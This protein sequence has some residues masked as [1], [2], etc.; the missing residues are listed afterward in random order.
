MGENVWVCVYVW[1]GGTEKREAE[2]DFHPVSNG[3]HTRAL[4]RRMG[5]SSGL[6]AD[7][8]AAHNRSSAAAMVARVDTN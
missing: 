1:E 3:Y 2:R 8:T 5:A 4:E 7:S 6:V